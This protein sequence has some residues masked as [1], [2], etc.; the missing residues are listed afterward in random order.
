[1]LMRNKWTLFRHPASSIA[2]SPRPQR[3]REQRP[4]CCQNVVQP[5]CDRL[6]SRSNRHQ[7][8]EVGTPGLV[9]SV[10]WLS[11]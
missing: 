3:H 1:L 7:S 10:R 5:S 8:L 6:K 4:C 9:T 2:Q 11:D